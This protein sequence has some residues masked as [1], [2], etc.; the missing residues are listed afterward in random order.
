MEDTVLPD[1]WASDND[2]IETHGKLD[3]CDWSPATEVYKLLS[4]SSP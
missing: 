3:E 4:L 1:E 2:A